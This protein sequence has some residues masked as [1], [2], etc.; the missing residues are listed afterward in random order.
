MIASSQAIGFVDII[1]VDLEWGPESMIKMVEPNFFVV[2]A[3]KAGTSSLHAWL[4]QHPEIFVS[5]SKEP[6]Y[7]VYGYGVSNW[8]DYIGLYQP[9]AGKKA[10]GDTS[11]SYLAAPES[12]DWIYK[13]FGKTKIII[14][15]RDPSR[16]AFSLYSW[17]LMEGYEKSK[18]FE[19]T[20]ALE[21]SR[22]NNSEFYWHNPG[23]FWD[24]IYFRGGLYH[25][26]V[27][28]YIDVF[29]KDNILIF[30]F[31]DLVKD[32]DGTFRKVCEFLDVST[33]VKIIFTRQNAS[34]RPRFVNLQF[35]LRTKFTSLVLSGAPYVHIERRLKFLAAL[36]DFNKRIGPKPILP[37]ETEKK[38][39][40]MYKSDIEKL[41][42]LIEMDLSSWMPL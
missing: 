32:P 9:G 42:D 15:L 2:G 12:P 34:I 17:M 25:E 35:F 39:R 30:L 19:E 27:K 40:Q 4:K 31:D 3:A 18:T 29:G 13:T 41:S 21:N 38:L 37:M 28:R 10:V 14:S 5:D 26:Q 20:L 16:R 22:F 36:I 23:Y 11:A 6:S 1:S 33:E 7:F 24:Y 8:D